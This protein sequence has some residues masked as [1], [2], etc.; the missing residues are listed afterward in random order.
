MTTLGQELGVKQ[1]NSEKGSLPRENSS[2]MGN[3]KSVSEVSSSQLRGSTTKF[4]SKKLWT[5]LFPPISGYRQGC[6]GSA[7]VLSLLVDHQGSEEV[8][9]G[10]RLRRQEVMRIRNKGLLLRLLFI[11][12]GM[13]LCKFSNTVDK[14]DFEGF[15]GYTHRV[16]SVLVFPSNLVTREK[17]LTSKRTCGLMVVENNE[18]P[19]KSRVASEI[20]SKKNYDGALCQDVVSNPNLDVMESQLACLNQMSEGINSLKTLPSIPIEAPNLV[21]DCP[22]E[23]EFSS[24]GGFQIEG[25]NSVGV[26]WRRVMIGQPSNEDLQ[27]IVKAWYPE[28]EP[29]A[30]KLIETFER[31]NY[32]PLY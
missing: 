14:A 24:L 25:R 9:L 4:G 17:W 19:T 27:S 20:L 5:S 2:A 13:K 11:Q 18:S 31:V 30:G 15:E 22:V 29:L 6:K 7:R 23:A 3:G 8:V 10:K 1:L 12:K 26:L 16:S 21:T 28:L 32:V